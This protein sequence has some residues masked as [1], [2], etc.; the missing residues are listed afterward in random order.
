MKVIDLFENVTQEDQ[1]RFKQWQRDCRKADPNCTF[2]GSV[3]MGAQAVN[4]VDPGNR[5]VG[6]W[7]GDTMTGKVYINK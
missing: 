5:V 2:A 4:W 3:G 7:D 6:D 1:E